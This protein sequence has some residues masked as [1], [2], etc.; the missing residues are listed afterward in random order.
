M[1]DMSPV[2]RP[3][4]GALL[5]LLVVASLLTA[6]PATSP[7]LAADPA[8]DSGAALPVPALEGIQGTVVAVSLREGDVYAVWRFHRPDG[9]R[10][11]HFMRLAA[12]AEDWTTIL[13]PPAVPAALHRPFEAG[14]LTLPAPAQE[15]D[16]C[17]RTRLVSAGVDREVTSCFQLRI[18]NDSGRLSRGLG[19]DAVQVEDVATGERVLRLPAGEYQATPDGDRV[20]T[21]TSDGH[22]RLRALDGSLVREWWT[23]DDCHQGGYGTLAAVSL[24]GAAGGLL[25]AVCPESPETPRPGDLVI[26]GSGVRGVG[27]LPRSQ[28]Q[29]G[30]HHLWRHVDVAGA[31]VLEL[32]DLSA[33]HGTHRVGPVISRGTFPWNAVA[34]DAD[35]VVWVTPERTLRTASMAWAGPVASPDAPPVPATR[36]IAAEATAIDGRADTTFQVAGTPVG[37]FENW[38]ELQGSGTMAD[39]WYPVS[40]VEWSTD[41]RSVGWARQDGVFARELAPGTSCFRGR[42]VGPGELRSSWSAPVCARVKASPPPTLK[43]TGISAPVRMAD[44]RWRIRFTYAFTD[45][46]RVASHRIGYSVT[47]VGKRM[48]HPGIFATPPTWQARTARYVDLP[49]RAGQGACF[50][51]SA[52]DNVGHRSDDSPVRCTAAPIDDR[53]FRMYT[54]RRLAVAGAHYGTLTRLRPRGRLVATS[55]SEARRVV[56]RLRVSRGP[57]PER[58]PITVYQGGLRLRCGWAG[59]TGGYATV[60]CVVPDGAYQQ[61]GYTRIYFNRRGWHRD[62]IDVDSVAHVRCDGICG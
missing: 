32:V 44:G 19:S 8:V 12:G 34:S 13:G 50:V 28:W 60:V 17:P 2:R 41:P 43:W 10:F 16:I 47:G 26:D 59:A 24:Q 6:L 11:A 57:Y 15:G 49:L 40:A 55:A 1:S 4:A 23:W 48:I 5:A 14:I 3:L 46:G 56:V 33:Q 30:H 53:T 27:R 36:I 62:Y 37:P 42:T 39:Y 61:H 38:Y 21:A 58:R 29:L 20:W 35:R 7:A 31:T 9:T 54:G 45:D 52:V 18:G 22:V 25:R 51:A